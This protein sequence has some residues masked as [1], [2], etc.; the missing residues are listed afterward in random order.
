MR[1]ESGAITPDQET[2]EEIVFPCRRR[3]R[4]RELHS[5]GIQRQFGSDHSCF[6][7]FPVCPPPCLLGSPLI[8][9][10]GEY[11]RQGAKALG[12]RLNCFP[13]LTHISPIR[14]FKLCL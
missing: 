6:V 8:C 14:T 5:F 9:N 2:E 12:V 10:Q 1:K 11:P 13:A 3:A 7:I 4:A